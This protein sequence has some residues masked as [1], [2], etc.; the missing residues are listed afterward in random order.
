V[1]IAYLGQMADISTEN[2]ISK[3][4]R[5]Q[6]LAW[7]TAAHEVRYFSLTPTT[8]VWQ[9][10]QPVPVEV[11]RRGGVMHRAVQSL[12]LARQI[13]AWRPDAIYFRYAYHSPGLVRLFREIPTVAEINSDDLAEYP[14][15]LSRAKVAYH[16]LTRNRI[17]RAV[18]GFITV[19][20]ELAGR[21]AGFGKPGEVIGNG[22][23][24]A[25]FPLLP[26][27]DSER[28]PRLVFMGSAGSPWHGLDRVTDLAR[29][30]PGMPIDIIGESTPAAPLPTAIHFHGPLTRERYE[31]LLRAATVAIGT[32]ALYTKHM[33]EACPLKAREYL[34]L[35]LP[36]IGAYQ[37]TDIPPDAD[38]FLR[39]PNN[40]E[41]LAPWRDRISTFIE[42]WRTRRVPRSAIAHLDVS[43][44]EAQRLAFMEKILAVSRHA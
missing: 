24:L 22:I 41:S 13:R 37:D 17:L 30:I 44:K 2:G 43:V 40:S 4:I 35:G 26:P 9:G 15:T 33:D 16:R 31:P 34:A 1:K 38:Y 14:L 11:I 19:T 6:C 5:T 39:L 25:D 23:A 8:A 10:M 29:L 3:K 36:V 28:P 42:Y 18:A 32:M 7:Q 21:L 12:R 27:P 20:N